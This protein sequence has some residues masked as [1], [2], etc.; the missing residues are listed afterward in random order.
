MGTAVGIETRGGV[1]TPLLYERLRLLA[2]DADGNEVPVRSPV[3][4]A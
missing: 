1:F 4:R 2:T 3:D